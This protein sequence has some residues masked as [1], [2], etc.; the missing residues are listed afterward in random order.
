MIK[1]TKRERESDGPERWAFRNLYFLSSHA[2][3]P[4]PTVCWP[5]VFGDL[6]SKCSFRLRPG[7]V[8]HVPGWNGVFVFSP[9]I[10]HPAVCGLGRHSSL[11][12]SSIYEPFLSLLISPSC[13]CLGTTRLARTKHLQGRP[14]SPTCGPETGLLI[15]QT[16]N[17]PH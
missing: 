6:W 17:K 5:L 1:W 11:Q 10:S 13:P 7:W 16:T 4:K 9:L 8:Q 15:Q 2:L 3:L 12:G 14:A